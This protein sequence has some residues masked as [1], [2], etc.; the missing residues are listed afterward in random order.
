[1]K[2]FIFDAVMAS[3]SAGG[4]SYELYLVIE[5]LVEQQ[6]GS[7]IFF[8]ILALIMSIFT[9]YF[10]GCADADLKKIFPSNTKNPRVS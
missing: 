8:A 5:K 10:W 3:I 1:M 4:L 9:G 6:Y 7:S 2:R